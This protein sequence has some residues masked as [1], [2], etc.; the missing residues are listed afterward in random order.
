M[1]YKLALVMLLLA[2]SNPVHAI[3]P[4]HSGSWYWA[5]QSGHGFSI[6]VGKLPDGSP[7][8]AVYWYTYDVL[9]NPIFFLGTGVPEGDIL[10]VEFHSPVG[11][12]FGVFDKDSVV[13]E[14]AGT[15]R[16]AFTDENI[17]TFQYTPSPFSVAN[18]GHSSISFMPLEKLFGVL[19]GEDVTALE[20]RVVQLENLL[21]KVTRL[22]DPNTGVDTIRFSDVNVQV[23]SGSGTT[24][25]AKTGTGNL[26][27]GYNE[28][29]DENNASVPCPSDVETEIYCNRRTGSHM[30]VIGDENNY[31]FYGGTVVECPPIFRPMVC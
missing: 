3:G 16:F 31:T 20:A 19:Q 21:Q 7:Y 15:G 10:D 24:D 28:L 25:G 17:A 26:I 4:Q 30:L 8:V 18:W 11:M 14:D 12:K 9:G 13:R 5:E 6:E 2:L 22:V 29:R 1:K 23:V 27:I